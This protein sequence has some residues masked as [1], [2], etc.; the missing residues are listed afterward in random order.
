MVLSHLLGRNQGTTPPLPWSLWESDN[1]SWQR[2]SSHFTISPA[3]LTLSGSRGCCPNTPED[4]IVPSGVSVFSLG[5]ALSSGTHGFCEFCLPAP[6]WELTCPHGK[7]AQDHPGS[8]LSLSVSLGTQ[9][10]SEELFPS[11]TDTLH[12]FYV[13]CTHLLTYFNFLNPHKPT[14]REWVLF[15]LLY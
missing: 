15:L 8:L 2:V 10:L 5:L 9:Q 12:T 4:R 11:G 13:C 6:P 1:I 7:R 14:L 3:V